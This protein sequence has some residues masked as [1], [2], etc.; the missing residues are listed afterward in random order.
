METDEP[1]KA[2]APPSEPENPLPPQNE[3]KQE[4]AEVKIF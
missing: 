4:I 2:E 3:I 1:I